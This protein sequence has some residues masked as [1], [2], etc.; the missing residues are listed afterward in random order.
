[1]TLQE[2]IDLG[3]TSVIAKVSGYQEVGILGCYQPFRSIRPITFK[4]NSK[5][6][7]LEHETFWINDE[8]SLDYAI[9]HDEA[10]LYEPDMYARADY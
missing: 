8:D 2:I 3:H 9:E 4:I 6:M 7:T 10:I 5:M 1:M